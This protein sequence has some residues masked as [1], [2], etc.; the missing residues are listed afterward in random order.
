MTATAEGDDHVITIAPADSKT[1]PP[2]IYSYVA[3]MENGVVEIY[4]I[5]TGKIEILP[6]FAA[7]TTGY[8]DRAH[9]KKVLDALEAVILGKASKDQLSYSIAGRSISRLSP[10]EIIEWR[11]TYRAEYLRLEREAGRGRPSQIHVRF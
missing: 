11:N 10:S 3:R 2:G 5:D 4:S 6:D 9:V 8:D 1:Y 7:A